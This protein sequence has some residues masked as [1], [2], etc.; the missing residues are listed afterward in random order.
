[1]VGGMTEA[2]QLLRKAVEQN[3][4]KNEK[5]DNESVKNDLK[6]C[7]ADA[8]DK[9]T[10]DKTIQLHM[11]NDRHENE[12]IMSAETSN[13][14]SNKDDECVDDNQNNNLSQLIESS[15]R[16]S[17]DPD[18]YYHDSYCDDF[19]ELGKDECPSDFDE[20]LKQNQKKFRQKVKLK[21][22][23]D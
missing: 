21:L 20:W 2:T 9:S 14:A 1:M 17:S 18:S 16:S 19:D 12:D 23:S 22:H 10:L 13:D 11:K 7:N 8:I 6:S 3:N 15:L 4:N 5:K